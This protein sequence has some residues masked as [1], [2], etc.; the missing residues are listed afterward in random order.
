MNFSTER[1]SKPVT[2]VISRVCADSGIERVPFISA[3]AE[4]FVL[5]AGRPAAEWV[6]DARAGGIRVLLKLVI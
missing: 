5:L 6:S 1:E 2:N 4:P 3:G